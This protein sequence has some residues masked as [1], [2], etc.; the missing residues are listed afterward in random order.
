MS[1]E[2]DRYPLPPDD[3]RQ[4]AEQI[5]DLQRQIDE[6]KARNQPAAGQTIRNGKSQYLDVDEDERVTI[7]QLGDDHYGVAVRDDDGSTVRLWIDERGFVSPYL[8]ASA[9]VGDTGDSLSTSSGSFVTL[10][11][12]QAETITHLGVYV[13]VDVSTPGG[14]TGE[15]RVHTTSGDTDPHTVASGAADFQQF[16]WLHP[17]PL[18]AGPIVFHVQARVTSGAGAITVTRP[19]SLTF[20]NPALCT[21][22]GL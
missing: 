13:W 18:S 19:R 15:V 16:K 10:Y 9:W 14:T 6:L 3:P 22:T 12:A 7:G 20:V 11:R 21:A 5:R 2:T 8:N 4:L 17:H 1:Q